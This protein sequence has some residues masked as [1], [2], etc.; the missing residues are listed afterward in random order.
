MP[1]YVYF[2]QGIKIP[3][4]NRY[5]AGYIISMVNKFYT[6]GYEQ[7]PVAD[8]IATMKS[9][10]IEKIIDVR[11]LPISRR[12]GFSKNVFRNLLAESGIDYVHLRGLGTPK[13]GRIASKHGDHARFMEIFANQMRSEEA[14]ADLEIAIELTQKNLCCLLC[15]ERLPE[16]CHRT[17]VAEAIARR[18]KQK[19]IPLDIKE[20]SHQVFLP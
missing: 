10:N 3:T 17:V 14:R 20:A 11:Q 18:T 8:F 19:I 15:Y 6:S 1:A 13:E 12:K 9:F 4:D 5:H 7:T 16:Q 2:M